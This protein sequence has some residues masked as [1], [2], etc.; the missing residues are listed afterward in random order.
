MSCVVVPNVARTHG[1]RTIAL[2]C[3]PGW[4]SL[5]SYGLAIVLAALAAFGAAVAATRGRSA[6]RAQ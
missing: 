3:A 6:L 2:S 5:S 4:L 1:A